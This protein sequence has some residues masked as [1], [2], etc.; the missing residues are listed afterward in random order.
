MN[1]HNI[2]LWCIGVMLLLVAASMHSCASKLKEQERRDVRKYESTIGSVIDI[3]KDEQQHYYPVILFF[4]P[5]SQKV[6]YKAK[7]EAHIKPRYKI[8]DVIQLQYDLINT[9][10]VYLIQDKSFE[11]SFLRIAGSVF[12][13]LGLVTIGAEWWRVRRIRQLIKNGLKVMSVFHSVGMEPASKWLGG[14][15]YVVYTKSEHET[16]G[17]KNTSYRSHA[18]NF[19][20]SP[21]LAAGR[22]VYV[23]IDAKNPEHYFVDLAFLGI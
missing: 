2:W 15:R 22:P 1:K 10:D 17:I 20:P 13:V 14:V 12:L 8:G 3:A 9:E 11:I 4:K 21:R 7:R 16:A 6:Y 19:D 23:F 5:D 18:L